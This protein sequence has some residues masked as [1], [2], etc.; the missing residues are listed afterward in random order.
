MRVVEGDGGGRIE[1]LLV[2]ERVLVVVRMG[3]VEGLG[4]EVVRVR[5]RHG[6]KGGRERKGGGN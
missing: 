2:L 4:K 6:E 5:G 1:R 3:A